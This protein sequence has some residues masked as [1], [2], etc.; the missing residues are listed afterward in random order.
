MRE[1]RASKPMAAHVLSSAMDI[2]GLS[3]RN[4]PPLAEARCQLKFPSC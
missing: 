2:A 4:W 3:S 1:V